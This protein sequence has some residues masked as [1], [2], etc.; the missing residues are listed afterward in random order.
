MPQYICPRLNS[1]SDIIVVNQ[2][3]DNGYR[4]VQILP[5]QEG[6]QIVYYAWMEKIE[7]VS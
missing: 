1:S 3:A 7:V 4:L 5:F 2:Y 6:D